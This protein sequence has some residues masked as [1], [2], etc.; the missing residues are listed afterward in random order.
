MSGGVPVGG[1]T[2]HPTYREIVEEAVLPPWEVQACGCSVPGVCDR[3]DGFAWFFY[4]KDT[5]AEVSD[6]MRGAFERHG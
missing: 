2:A 1:D 4:N 3:C 6:L 5:G